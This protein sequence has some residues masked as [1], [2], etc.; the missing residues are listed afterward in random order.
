MTA[1]EKMIRYV[2][3]CEDP[4]QLRSIIKNARARGASELE[5]SAFKKL[6]SILPEEDPETV[7]YE[8][9]RSIHALEQALTDERGKTTRL[10]RTRQK[11]GRDGV[12]KTLEDLT[13]GTKESDGFKMLVER[14]MPEFLAEAIVLR[15]SDQFEPSVAAAA[16]RRLESAGVDLAK[17]G[18]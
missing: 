9:W 18:T 5:K 10:S 7:E 16:R 3:S 11:V 13:L 4:E 12:L 14:G 2:S 1:E 17:L 15:R 6:I 8:F